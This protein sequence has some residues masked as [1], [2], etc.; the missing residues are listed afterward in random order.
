MDDLKMFIKRTDSWW[1]KIKHNPISVAFSELAFTL[2]FAT[3]PFWFGG[4][5]LLWLG[6]NG[7]LGEAIISTMSNGELLLFSTT[8]LAPVFWIIL[9]DPKGA[10]I[11]QYRLRY[12]VAVLIIMTLCAGGF[13]IIKAREL[14]HLQTDY[15]LLI[16]SSFVLAAASL[17]LRFFALA[18]HNQRLQNPSEAMKED[19]S[20]YVDSYS[21]HRRI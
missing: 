8:F 21:K 7:S 18:H 15:Q 4:I 11:F 17:I 1:G 2:V 9:Q 6:A 14:F 20:D 16:N 13:S 3:F 10:G 12:T 19:E 5:V